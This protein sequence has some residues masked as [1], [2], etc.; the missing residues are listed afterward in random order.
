MATP[1]ACAAL[2]DVFPVL[3]RSKRR[4]AGTTTTPPLVTLALLLEH[5]PLRMSEV[6]EQLFLDLSTVSRQVTHL[7]QKGLVDSTPDPDDGRSQRV[8]IT[9][10]GVAELRSHRRAVVGRLVDRL[11]DW[12]D[13]EIADLTRL[14][15]KLSRDT[16]PR[17]ERAPRVEDPA[18]HPDDPQVTLPTT[19][20]QRNA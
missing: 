9:P 10:A 1:H 3:L 4:F 6:A 16:S 5:G 2:V 7:R 11:A 13:A 20:P 8:T 17:D 15:E 12:D 18:H 14:L 19:P